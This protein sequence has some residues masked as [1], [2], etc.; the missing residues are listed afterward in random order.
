VIEDDVLT[1][2]G[3][4]VTGNWAVRA[5]SGTITCAGTVTTAVRLLRSITTVPPGGAATESVTVPV[6]A[7]PPTTLVGL[8]LTEVGVTTRRDRVADLT[9]VP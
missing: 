2:V 7:A 6:D 1:V 4:V 3:K 9:A 8:R 5:P